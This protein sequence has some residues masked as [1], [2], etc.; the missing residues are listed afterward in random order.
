MEVKRAGCEQAISGDVAS[1]LSTGLSQ[2]TVKGTTANAARAA[3][4]TRP[5]IGKTGTTQE[6]K[7]VAFVG[8]VENFAV[9]STVFAD[10]SSPGTICNSHP[11]R[12]GNGCRT[13]FGGTVAAPPYFEAMKAI[14]GSG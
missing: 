10:G 7:S 12:I 9:S 2:D 8:G 11:V 13:A 1:R 5:D 4:W 6:N 3:H 14:L